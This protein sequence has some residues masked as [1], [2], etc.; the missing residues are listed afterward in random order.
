MMIVSPCKFCGQEV[1]GSSMPLSGAFHPQC[2]AVYEN[3]KRDGI[4]LGE[5]VE[6]LERAV[7]EL[8][9]SLDI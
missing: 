9:P 8:N 5:R 6:R 7:K 1:R 4:T 3:G 2:L